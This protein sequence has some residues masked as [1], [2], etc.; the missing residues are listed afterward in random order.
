MVDPDDPRNS[1]YD[2]DYLI[3]DPDAEARNGDVIVA[4][5]DGEVDSVEYTAQVTLRAHIPEETTQ[6]F[7]RSVTDI[8][9][10]TAAVKTVGTQLVPVKI[11]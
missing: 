11:R 9:S 2:G 8:S 7:C 6:D 1:I 3:V 10:G 5:L 4:R